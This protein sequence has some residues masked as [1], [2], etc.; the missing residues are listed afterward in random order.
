MKKRN[1]DWEGRLR[2]LLLGEKSVPDSLEI[3]CTELS[4]STN[5]DAK[6][7]A[8]GAASDCVFIAKRQS[9]GRGRLGR[10]FSSGYGGL[11][12]SFLFKRELSPED[13]LKI[14][15]YAAVATAAAVRRLTGLDVKIKWVNDIF[16]GERKLAG[17]LCEGACDE[18]G[19]ISHAVLG[20]GV[21]IARVEDTELSSIASSISEHIEDAPEPIE[22][23]AELIRQI[24][25]KSSAD[26][27]SV[28]EE[29]RSLSLITGKRVRVIKPAGEYFARVIGIDDGGALLL[30][31]D[32]GGEERLMSA[33]VSV[34]F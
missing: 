7:F 3:Y 4:E 24:Y 9:H 20:I 34:R 15:V 16:I 21:N 8:R 22:L 1:K 11:Y 2:E 25:G 5:T 27:S 28:V 18:F 17:I 12:M 10:S 31:K 14:T 26:F 30:E 23:A 13:A 29:Y 6:N 33:E 32:E 19:K